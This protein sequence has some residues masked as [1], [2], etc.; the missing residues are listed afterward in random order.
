MHPNRKRK[1]AATATVLVGLVLGGL[2]LSLSTSLHLWQAQTIACII[3]ALIAT[4][5]IAL[6]RLN[7]K[8]HQ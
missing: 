3:A 5:L 8:D 4:G 6:D 7:R 2:A 1:L